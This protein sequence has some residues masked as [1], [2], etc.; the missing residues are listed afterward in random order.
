M[1][2]APSSPP[3]SPL[4]KSEPMEAQLQRV[5]W[6]RPSLQP[7]ATPAAG[8]AK[9]P[10][11][12]RRASAES[13]LPGLSSI[14]NVPRTTVTQAPNLQSPP[15]HYTYS[16]SPEPSACADYVLSRYHGDLGDDDPITGFLNEQRRRQS[17]DGRQWRES[18]LPE[19]LHP[20]ALARRLHIKV[21]YPQPSPSRSPGYDHRLVNH[22]RKAD[23]LRH[24]RHGGIRKK[25]KDTPHCNKRYTRE[26]MDF[27]RYL[28][29]DV[30]LTWNEIAHQVQQYFPDSEFERGTQGVQG[31]YYRQNKNLPVVDLETNALKYLP[32]GH[33]DRW[34]KK[35]RDQ[36][37]K[38]VYGLINIWPEVALTYPWVKEEHKQLAAKLAP[39]RCGE[40]EDAYRHAVDNGL[41]KE[42]LPENE[43]ACCCYQ[44]REK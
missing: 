42:T 23:S 30:I 15:T 28:K 8:I 13:V 12:M 34:E 20:P 9:L 10:P 21:E 1:S 32:N 22:A 37:D 38:K 26:Q 17:R 4:R 25:P 35:C 5:P 31:V 27:I 33:I 36:P 2:T 3:R 39:R 41:W 16:T 6:R 7:D 44:K 40:R 19:A 18:P 24:I 14:L 43:C 29:V 11:M